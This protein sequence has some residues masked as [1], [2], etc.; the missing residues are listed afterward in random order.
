MDEPG[1][2]I[3]DAAALYWLAPSTL[4]WWE[5]QGVLPLP[6]R[7]DGRRIYREVDLR[8][9]GLAHLHCVTG[10]M[11]LRSAA[12]VTSGK[13]DA[14][15]WHRVV[16]AEMER[17]D[18]QI[19]ELIEARAYLA[20]MRLCPGDDPALCPELDGEFQRRTP[21]RARQRIDTRRGRPHKPAPAG[22]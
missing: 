13:T 1:V 10:R 9:I 14:A 3:G 19:Q 8:R 16:E 7:V 20:H 21:R 17:L 18:R 22:E 5:R 12:A 4:R 15:T 2:S 6:D 11:P